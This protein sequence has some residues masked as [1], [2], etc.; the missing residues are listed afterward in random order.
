MKESFEFTVILLFLISF[1]LLSFNL[2]FAQVDCVKYQN[3]TCD[4][5]VEINYIIFT[6]EGG[7]KTYF[8][9]DR[10]SYNITIRNIGK[11]I[12]NTA[13]KVYLENPRE[14]TSLTYSYGISL[15]PNETYSLYPE[16]KNGREIYYYYF[17]LIGPYT[18]KLN[19]STPVRFYEFY[20]DCGYFA[21][22]NFRI[23]FDAISRSDYEWKK[24][25]VDMTKEMRDISKRMEISNKFTRTLS[26]LVLIL[27]VVNVTCTI[28]RLKHPQERSITDF[29]LIL[30]MVFLI[31]I[32]IYSFL[33]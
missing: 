22:Y 32:L 1:M 21:D 11:D 26:I 9:G 12:I 24:E 18:L 31:C 3:I 25:M 2:S 15:E 20:P 27:T 7:K 6:R 30:I 23:N 17:D 14:V 29:V 5:C 33:I 16:R 10:F 13:V 8:V 19:S 28:Y 4:Q